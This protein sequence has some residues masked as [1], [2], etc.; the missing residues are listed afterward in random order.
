MKEIK[1]ETLKKMKW[2]DIHVHGMK[3]S[4]LL[5]MFT[6]PKAIQRQWQKIHAP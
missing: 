4:V 2:K 6:L 5:K 1:H 3:D